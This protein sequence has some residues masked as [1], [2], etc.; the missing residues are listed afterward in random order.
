MGS[1]EQALQI[2]SHVHYDL[3]C[4]P[5]EKRDLYRSQLHYDWH[6]DHNTGNGDTGNQGIHQMDVCRWFLGVD[7]AA[8]RVVSIGGRLGYADAGDTPNSQLIYFDYPDAPL[9]FETRGLP[10][11]MRAQKNWD[12]NTMDRFRGGQV[13][14]I[15]QCERGH[16]LIGAFAV[17]RIYDRAGKAIEDWKEGADLAG[18]TGDD[19]F[20]NWLQ[21]VAAHD[22]SQLHAEILEGHLSTTLCL[23]GEVSHRVG[24]EMAVEEIAERIAGND[25][26]SS[27]F[28]RMTSHLRANEVDIDGEQKRLTM[29]AEL[30]FDNT[31]EDFCGHSE[32]NSLLTRNYRAQFVV[33]DLA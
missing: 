12:S 2:P 13:A 22:R 33:P 7:R 27:A 15:V 23:T 18:D 24:E 19:H 14:A 11:S 32:A 28:D 9:I 10:R 30:E 21:A 8:P 6:W 4:G 26:L 16:V 29:G 3:W 17:P 25:V 20:R 31:T 5:A 1:L